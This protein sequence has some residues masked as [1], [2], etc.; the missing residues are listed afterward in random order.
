MR[1][2]WCVLCVVFCALICSQA[3]AE[4]I[5]YWR[6]ESDLTADSDSDFGPYDGTNYNPA[7]GNP[8]VESGSDSGSGLWDPI[9]NPDEDAS[10]VNTSYGVFDGGDYVY[11]NETGSTW[12]PAS[13]FT[14]EAMTRFGEGGLAGESALVSHW[15][16]GVSG[17]ESWQFGLT[18]DEKPYLKLGGLTDPIVPDTSSSIQ[19]LSANTVYALAAS[20]DSSGE[21]N[22]YSKAKGANSWDKYTVANSGITS[23]VNASTAELVM[24]AETDGN[25]HFFTGDMDEVRFSSE[26]LGEAEL[27]ATPE[28]GTTCLALVA[29]AAGVFAVWRKKSKE[30]SED[31]AA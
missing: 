21:V 1:L 11:T 7:V 17:E 20:W 24:G 19:S 12:E 18:A 15:R 31:E 28:P 8:G 26:A 10:E 5:G 27:L 25:S 23:L 16:E 30:N 9:P 14:I 13:G 4:T 29:A 22:L 2:T 3:D 6:Y